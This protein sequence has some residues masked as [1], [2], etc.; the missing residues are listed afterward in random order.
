MHFKEDESDAS[1]QA[2]AY[3]DHG[4]VAQIV[5]VT[6]HRTGK[7]QKLEQHLHKAYNSVNH[8]IGIKRLRKK[9]FAKPTIA[10]MFREIRRTRSIVKAGDLETPPISRTRSLCQGG[11]D[12]PKLFN[13]ILDESN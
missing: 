5:H 10:S 3:H 4:G 9:G 7:R 2:E 8:F 12:A 1:L 13:L 11:P 6:G